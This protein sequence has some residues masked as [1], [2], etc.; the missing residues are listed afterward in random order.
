[1]NGDNEQNQNKSSSCKCTSEEHER[2][3]RQAL[4]LIK[5]LAE[6]HER[7]FRQEKNMLSLLKE[8][9]ANTRDGG[10]SSRFSS[11]MTALMLTNVLR[12]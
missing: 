7:A 6:R 4:E 1:M 2:F 10:P 11:G 3:D 5:K 8:I 9:G 12:K